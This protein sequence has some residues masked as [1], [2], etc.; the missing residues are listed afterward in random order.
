MLLSLVWLLAQLLGVP[1]LPTAIAI[2]AVLKAF[3]GRLSLFR[4]SGDGPSTQVDERNRGAWREAMTLLRFSSTELARVLIISKLW[5][6]HLSPSCATS[7]QG[8]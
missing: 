2:S 6:L 7:R 8:S 4:S 1:S 5:Q 3:P